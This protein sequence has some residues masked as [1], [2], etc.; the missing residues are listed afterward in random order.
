MTV[1]DLRTREIMERCLS[2]AIDL[3]TG[4]LTECRNQMVQP[5]MIY[6]Q[7]VPRQALA[8]MILPSG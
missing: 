6:R 2:M 5:E 4:R 7:S 1:V 8:A 3:D